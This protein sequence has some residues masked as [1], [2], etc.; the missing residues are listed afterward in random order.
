MSFSI[1]FYTK[2][3]EDSMGD[4]DTRPGIQSRD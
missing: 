4:G 1:I 2:C 3:Y